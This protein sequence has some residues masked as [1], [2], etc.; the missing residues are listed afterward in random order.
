MLASSRSRLKIFRQ[1]W[2]FNIFTGRRTNQE[3]W[4]LGL[5]GLP[6]CWRSV[7]KKGSSIFC[8]KWAGGFHTETLDDRKALNS[9]FD[10][11]SGGLGAAREVPI[12]KQRLHRSLSRGE[13]RKP[14]RG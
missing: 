4:R 3:K 12:E 7:M 9:R 1:G 5:E 13:E 8:E 10:G 2:D 6:D 11:V 14:L